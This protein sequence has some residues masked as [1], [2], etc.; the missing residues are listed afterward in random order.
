MTDGELLRE[1]LGLGLGLGVLG[2]G[3]LLLVLDAGDVLGGRADREAAGD[4]VVAGVAG[5]DADE[6]ADL[7]QVGEVLGEDHVDVVSHRILLTP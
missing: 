6:L 3:D 4:E 5:A 7:A 2:L 1:L